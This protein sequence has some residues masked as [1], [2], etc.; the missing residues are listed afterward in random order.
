[1]AYGKAR[2]SPVNT[3]FQKLAVRSTSQR[4]SQQNSD[5][6]DRSSEGKSL[7]LNSQQTLLINSKLSKNSRE[8]LISV[9]PL[10]DENRYGDAAST[11]EGRG[12][13]YHSR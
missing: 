3:V 5:L 2:V 9:K 12:S 8:M 4:I 6:D 13:R 7:V 11:K 1:M 10:H